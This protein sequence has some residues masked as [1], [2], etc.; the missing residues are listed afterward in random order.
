MPAI[1]PVVLGDSTVT[2]AAY[3]GASSGRFSFSPSFMDS[4]G[5]MTWY[6]MDDDEPIDAREK[7]SLSVRQPSKGS[8]VARVIAKVVV[9]VM[10]ED[11]SNLKVGEGIATLEFVIPKRMS[12]VERQRLHGL[13]ANF[14]NGTGVTGTGTTQGDQNDYVYYASV[15]LASPY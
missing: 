5:V 11:D 1:A 3:S 12:G 7:L 9:P 13:A 2:D 4:A 8:Q 6:H 15:D 10:D 14:F